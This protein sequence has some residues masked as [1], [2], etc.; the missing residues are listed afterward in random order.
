VGQMGEKT[1]VN[2]QHAT[3]LHHKNL[4][5]CWTD[6]HG[7]C[8]KRSTRTIRL[9]LSSLPSFVLHRLFISRL[10]SPYFI[11]HIPY[12]TRSPFVRCHTQPILLLS[13]CAIV[14]SLCYIIHAYMTYLLPLCFASCPQANNWHHFLKTVAF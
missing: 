12:S 4:N 5:I 10:H 1:E 2:E 9:F 3:H 13:F 8:L 7:A 14:F 11:S 6:Q